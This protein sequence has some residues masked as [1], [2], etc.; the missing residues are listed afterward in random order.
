VQTAFDEISLAI[1]GVRRIQNG[2]VSYW[3]F[4]GWQGKKVGAGNRG[5][6][7]IVS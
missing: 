5:Q 2:Y 7:A 3:V 6:R 1:V 4:G